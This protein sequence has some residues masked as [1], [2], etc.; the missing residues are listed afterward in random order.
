MSAAANAVDAKVDEFLKA[1]LAQFDAGSKRYAEKNRCATV[2]KSPFFMHVVSLFSA[3]AASLLEIL[4]TLQ[5][6]LYSN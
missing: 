4:T 3:N 5:T 6:L 1:Y 2:M